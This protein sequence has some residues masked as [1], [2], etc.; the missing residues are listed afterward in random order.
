M[1]KLRQ[2]SL[3]ADGVNILT[4]GQLLMYACCIRKHN[5]NEELFDGD[6]I[7]DE[8]GNFKEARLTDTSALSFNPNLKNFYKNYA[9]LTGASNLSPRHAVAFYVNAFDFDFF[10]DES[11]VD[12]NDMLDTPWGADLIN[13][14]KD[15]VRPVLIY[16]MRDFAM[17]FNQLVTSTALSATFDRTDG[18]D[19][20]SII[21]G[22]NNLRVNI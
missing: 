18:P 11:G 8:D 5:L 20:G 9:D 1:S 2:Y 13:K 17:L 3:V 21:D 7:F 19:A 14:Y 6:S 22:I 4:W 15:V 16:S 12:I 10:M